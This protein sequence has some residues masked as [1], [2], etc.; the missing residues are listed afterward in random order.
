MPGENDWPIRTALWNHPDGEQGEI[1]LFSKVA[2][3][4]G[5]AW[6]G[7]SDKASHCDELLV[8]KIGA[9]QRGYG[10][11]QV[12]DCR[13]RTDIDD[14]DFTNHRPTEDEIPH[15]LDKGKLL[16]PPYSRYY[17][18][19]GGTREFIERV[20]IFDKKGSPIANPIRAN[21]RVSIRGRS[22]NP[23]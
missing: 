16:K 15:T 12:I 2:S 21:V 17:K 4:R 11:V 3:N 6:V 19:I 7:C 9:K 8:I 20:D 5:Y 13:D 22:L 23:E 18:M 10:I 1:E 14:E